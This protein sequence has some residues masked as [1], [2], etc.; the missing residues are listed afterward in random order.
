M[1]RLT[2]IICTGLALSCLHAAAQEELPDPALAR[3]FQS[4]ALNTTF[5]PELPEAERLAGLALLWSETKYNFANF[6]L[7]PELDWDARYLEFIPRVQAAETTLD[8]YR[9]LMEFVAGLKDGH[10]S[11]SPLLVS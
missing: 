10:S 3:P 1:S 7:V 9:A 4:E 5:R 8:Y 2:F 11:I 6:D